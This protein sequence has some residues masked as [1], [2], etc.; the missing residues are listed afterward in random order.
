MGGFT[1]HSVVTESS[2][3]GLFEFVTEAA[4]TTKKGR[5]AHWTNVHHYEITPDGDGSRI[6]YTVRIVRI[7]SLPGMLAIFNVPGLSALA[8]RAAAAG[9]RRGVRNLARMAEERG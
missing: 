1:D 7:S 2:R 5:E 3:P 8:L 9:E 6:A 4:L